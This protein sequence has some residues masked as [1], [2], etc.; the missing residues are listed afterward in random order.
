MD[1]NPKVSI[2]IPHYNNYNIIKDCLESI[3]N[4]TFENF[5]T[6]VVDNASSDNSFKHI[7]DNHSDINLIKSKYNRGYAGGCNYGAEFARGKYLLFLN[8]DTEQEANFIEPLVDF[9]D[10]NSNV[11]SVQPKIKNFYAKNNF[12]YAGAS[13]GFIDYLVFPFCRGRIFN[14][15]E[16]DNNQYDDNIKVF[17]T[18]GTAFLTRNNIFKQLNGFDE[19]LFAHMEEI[20]Y[21]WKGIL[22]GYEN[23]VIPESVVH[24][25]GGQTLSYSSANKTY[26]NHRNS[27]ILLLTNF[28]FSRSI[29]TF[30]FRFIVE[31]V[32]SIYD[33]IKLRP[34]HFLMHYKALVYLLFNINYLIKRRKFNSKIRIKSD[35]N[36]LS[37]SFILKES[38]VKKYFLLNNKTYN[39]INS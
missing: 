1:N 9:L 33:L 17:W 30:L 25:K 14:T 23:W 34:L 38:I 3:K 24:H 8:N 29:C 26:L 18:S 31:I 7:K 5:E 13:G 19:K 37:Q 27:M 12:D 35:S 32:S 11:C 2:I 15:V 36:I 16:Q 10:K 22:C 20:D 6:I 39:K 21:C 4:L 28:K